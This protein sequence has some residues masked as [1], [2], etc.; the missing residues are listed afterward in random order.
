MYSVPKQHLASLTLR[1]L[2]YLAVVG[3]QLLDNRSPRQ[4]SGL[5]AT[6]IMKVDLG[7]LDLVNIIFCK[8]INALKRSVCLKIKGMRVI[9]G[10]KR[11]I[12]FL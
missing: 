1:Q 6:L 5:E 7:R 9:K 8:L 12:M 3:P 2:Q 11:T 10:I 4:A